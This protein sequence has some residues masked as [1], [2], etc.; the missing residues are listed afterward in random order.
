MVTCGHGRVTGGTS[1]SR[2]ATS[3][4]RRGW[5][6][7]RAP[8]QPTPPE[9]SLGARGDTQILV[10][11]H[12]GRVWRA[13]C[14]PELPACLPLCSRQGRRGHHRLPPSPACHPG[15]GELEGGSCSSGAC[16][17]GLGTRSVR[18]AALAPGR[19]GVLHTSCSAGPIN[20]AGFSE[21]DPVCASVCAGVCAWGG[22]GEEPGKMPGR[23]VLPEG[24]SSVT[25]ERHG[26]VTARD[27]G[28]GRGY[29]SGAIGAIGQ[30]GASRHVL[31]ASWL[32]GGPWCPLSE[33]AA[34]TAPRQPR[35][36]KLLI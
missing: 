35:T 21:K 36:M 22:E 19:Q 8:E 34:S 15:N 25:D 18:S 4:S 7:N 2:E 14:H 11:G 6:R 16:W 10:R 30:E 29:R 23:R 31:R 26:H 9:P 1:R 20:S 3:R 13:P 32:P 27:G 24:T 33:W 17:A 12:G 28:R 5:G